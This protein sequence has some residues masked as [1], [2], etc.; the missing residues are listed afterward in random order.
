[1]KK[2]VTILIADRNPHIREYLRRELTH[3]GLNVITTD[4]LRA[5]FYYAFGPVSTDLLVID[6]DLP[7]MD[8]ARLSARLNGRIPPLPLVWHP[9]P[10]S[11]CPSEDM[12]PPV[13]V[14]EKGSGS[15]ELLKDVINGLANKEASQREKT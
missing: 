12:I 10:G 3:D 14:I 9:L 15:V 5:V 4:S 2:N 8:T 13:V 11:R 6:P 1:M 7:D